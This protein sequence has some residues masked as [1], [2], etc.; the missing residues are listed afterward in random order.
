[1]TSSLEKEIKYLDEQ[2]RSSNVLVSD[3]KFDQLE[4][5]LQRIDPTTDYFIIKNNLAL[6]SLPKDNIE[7]FIDGLLPRTRY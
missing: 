3:A 6:P 4:A 1:M 2:Y 7:E 5:N